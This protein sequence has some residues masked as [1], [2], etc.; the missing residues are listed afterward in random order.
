LLSEDIDNIVHF[1]V[2][3]FIIEHLESERGHHCFLHTT[4]HLPFS[5]LKH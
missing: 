4:I 2:Q 1:I 3:K 5:L